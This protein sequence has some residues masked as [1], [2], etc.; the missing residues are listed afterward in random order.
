MHWD[1]K[2]W[3]ELQRRAPLLCV[4]GVVVNDKGE[5]L[6]TKRKIEPFKGYWHLPGGHVDFEEMVEKAV[7]RV[8]KEESGIDAKRVSLVGVYSDPGRDPRGHFVTVG[9]LMKPVKGKERSD[10]QASSIKYFKELPEKM[11]FDAREIVKDGL[12]IWTTLRKAP[13]GD[14]QGKQ[15]RHNSPHRLMDRPRVS[16]T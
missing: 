11:G 9:F 16:G 1:D 14:T 3:Q 10:F 7:V 6:L 5:V 12:K 13:Y 4:D 8:V 2:F 15:G